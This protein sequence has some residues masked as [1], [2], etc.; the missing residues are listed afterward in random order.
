MKADTTKIFSQDITIYADKPHKDIYNF[1]GRIT[2]DKNGEVISEPLNLENVI[3]MNTVLATQS[4]I[5]AVIYTGCETRAMQNTAKPRNKFGKIEEE[6]NYYSILLCGSSIIAGIVFLFFSGI[7]NRFDI[8][9]I[10]FIIIFSSV[11]PISLKVTIDVARLFFYS[12]WVMKDT[13]I[14]G[15]IVRNSNIPE[16]LG[17]ITYLLTDKTGTLTRN[18]MEMRKVHVGTICYTTELNDEVTRLLAK[19][20]KTRG[21]K[22]RDLGTKVYDMVRALALCHNV[23]P[24]VEDGV[25]SYQASSPDEVALVQWCENVGVVLERRTKDQIVIGILG[26]MLKT[27]KILYIFPFTS[28]TKRMGVIMRDLETKEV[29][30][31]LK[32]ADMIMKKIVEKNDWLDEEVDNMAREGLRTLVIGMKRLNGEEFAEFEK[33]YKKANLAIHDRAVQIQAVVCQLERNLKLLGLTGVEDKLQENVNQ[34]LENLRNAGVKIWMLTGDKIETAIS[35]SISSRLFLKRNLYEILTVSSREDAWEK[36]TNLKAKMIN[37]V[38]IDGHSLQVMI[39]SF[40]KEF[41]LFAATLDAVV[42]CRCTPT[43]KALVARNLRM[44]TS[45]RVACIGDGGNDVSMITEA[46][47]G[48]GIVGKEGN[49]ASLAAD[50]SI[51]KF[52]DIT[53][54]F[55]WH[56]RNCYRGTAKLIQFIIHRGT[57]ISVMQGIF[58]AIFGFAP[59]ALYQGLIM[60]GYVC[61]YTFC[62]MWCIILDRDVSK[63]NVFRYPEL[64]KEMVQNKILSAKSFAAWNLISFYQGSVIMILTFYQFSHELLSLVTITF[65]CLVLNELL[66]VLLMVSTI[67]KW[68]MLS[69]IIS[70]VAY[71]LSFFILKDELKLPTSLFSFILKLVLISAIAIFFSII[72][73]LYL[74]IIRPPAY[75]KI[76]NATI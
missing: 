4:V 1:I 31:F 11:I 33:N 72:E 6:I 42:C 36:L 68:M 37:Y 14:P 10:R 35:I 60:V 40:M 71:I 21:H 23:T 41:I 24:V 29:F 65:S 12:N 45:H 64:Y 62:P 76:A 51:L 30:F 63:V 19:K 56:G 70:L 7:S 58:S 39:D 61:I 73:V 17:R 67:N 9:L 20:M 26:E 16:E 32:G 3:W 52:S 5:G 74:K 48:I 18:E 15:C 59:I 34:S 27:Y 38:I 57:I 2:S 13:D 44:L 47:V 43:Q 25:R 75:S 50:F 54:L 69:Q 8:T 28:D 22:T 49:Q 46:N 55:F 53:T 66:V